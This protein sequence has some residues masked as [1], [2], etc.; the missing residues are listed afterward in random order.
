MI[1]HQPDKFYSTTILAV[2][3]NGITVIAGDG[4]VTLGHA[5][6]KRKNVEEKKKSVLNMKE[7]QQWHWWLGQKQNVKKKKQKKSV[8]NKK[9]W[10]H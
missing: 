6:M 7:W 5:V 8:L 2:K 1:T 3:R 10:Q 9:E 4:Q